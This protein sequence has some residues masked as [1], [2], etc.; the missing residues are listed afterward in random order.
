MKT[1]SMPEYR[2]TKQQLDDQ[3]AAAIEQRDAQLSMMEN[4]DKSKSRMKKQALEDAVLKNAINKRR[5]KMSSEGG[6]S[7][8]PGI[9]IPTSRTGT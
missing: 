8:S 1:P 4:S 3:R 9:Q 5:G 6:S 7:S 2:P